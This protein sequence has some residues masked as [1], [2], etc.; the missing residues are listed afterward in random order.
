MKVKKILVTSI[1][2]IYLFAGLVLSSCVTNNYGSNQLDYAI[3]YYVR[4]PVFVVRDLGDKRYLL[5]QNEFKPASNREVLYRYYNRQTNVLTKLHPQAWLLE[6]RSVYTKVPV[7]YTSD[8][9]LVIAFLDGSISFP[10]H[11]Y[12]SPEDKEW[13]SIHGDMRILLSQDGG[14]TFFSRKV[15]VPGILT[16]HYMT[17]LNMVFAEVSHQ[18]IYV[19]IISNSVKDRYQYD[20]SAKIYKNK[21]G[22]EIGRQIEQPIYDR[23]GATDMK[24]EKQFL[25]IIAIP[26]PELSNQAS[27]LSFDNEAT[28]HQY[29][30]TLAPLIAQRVTGKQL[31]QYSIAAAEIETKPKIEEFHDVQFNKR[32]DLIDY[33]E[34]LKALHPEWAASQ[35]VNNIPTRVKYET[36]QKIAEKFAK[37]PPLPDDPIAWIRF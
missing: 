31:V 37:S 35:K 20:M 32:Q 29:E 15:T 30:V 4:G 27:P 33:I 14:R 10:E 8:D 18:T 11:T 19:G 36:R 1:F 22:L 7:R 16:D 3:D 28:R 26:L 34:P 25:S 21:E 5:A 6:N 13:K 12:P 17:Q 24:Y 2:I 23:L 9:P